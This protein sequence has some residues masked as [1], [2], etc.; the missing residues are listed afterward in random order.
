MVKQNYAPDPNYYINFVS[1]NYELDCFSKI[2][3]TYQMEYF[4]FNFRKIVRSMI[5]IFLPFCF[6]LKGLLRDV[7]FLVIEN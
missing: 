3:P 7:T 4:S 1:D 6:S 2:S 5:Q